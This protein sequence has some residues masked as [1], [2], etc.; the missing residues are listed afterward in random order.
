L[1]FFV[2]C[3]SFCHGTTS[4]IVDRN[5]VYIYKILEKFMVSGKV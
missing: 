2:S 5:R 3:I 1:K 4:E